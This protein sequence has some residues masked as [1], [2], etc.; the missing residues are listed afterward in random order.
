MNQRARDLLKVPQG[1]PPIYHVGQLLAYFRDSLFWTRTS[2]IND[3]GMTQLIFTD[4]E[5]TEHSVKIEI[6]NQFILISVAP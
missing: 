4:T 6:L 1:S 2:T 3:A 5:K